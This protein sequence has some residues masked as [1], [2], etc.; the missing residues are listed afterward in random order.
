MKTI[1]VLTDFSENATHA[2]ASAVLLG[3]KLRTNLLLFHNYQSLPV[4]PFYAGGAMV[5]EEP[6]WFA[7]ESK[8]HLAELEK[9]LDPVLETV[10]EDDIKPHIHSESNEGNLVENIKLITGKKDIELI[11]MGSRTKDP[12]DHFFFGSETTSVIHHAKSPVLIIPPNNDLSNLNKI[13][14]ATDFDKADFD[15]IQYLI[16]IGKVFDTEIEVIHVVEPG[17]TTAVK[18]AK[19]TLFRE[20]VAKLKYPKITYRKIIGKDVVKR[21]NRL[22]KETG[23]GLLAMVHQH[24]YLF[25][26]MLKH[27]VTKEIMIDQNIPLMVF[28]SI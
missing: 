3:A 7:E 15:A 26:R 20:H 17:D 28:P 5:A 14:F 27:S 12:I 6:D 25:V 1:L 23:T 24:H 22:C 13:V 21:L 4:T 11:V 10:D 8:K 18:T 9:N 16:K 2:A 19:E